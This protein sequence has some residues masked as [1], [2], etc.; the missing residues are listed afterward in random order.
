MLSSSSSI[1]EVDDGPTTTTTV[2]DDAPYVD[3]RREAARYV[4]WSATAPHGLRATTESVDDALR[5]SRMEVMR[6][7]AAMRASEE[8]LSGEKPARLLA[9]P[10]QDAHFLHSGAR[11]PLY[12][13]RATRHFKTI[14]DLAAGSPTKASGD[15]RS[16]RVVWR[17]APS[18]PVS[19]GTRDGTVVWSDPRSAVAEKHRAA[20][21]AVKPHV[22]MK[23]ERMMQSH[24]RSLGAVKPYG[25]TR[26]AKQEDSRFVPQPTADSNERYIDRMQCS[27]PSKGLYVYYE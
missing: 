6:T 1:G 16:S 27:R 10:L 24:T 20:V 4:A 9:P 13:R 14:E 8:E 17:G 18:Y 19:E 5:R 15:R 11:K 7:V 12:P 22:A 23:V 2:M 26:R 25:L 21:E 3:M